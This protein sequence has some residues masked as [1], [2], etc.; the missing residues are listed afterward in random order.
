M[1]TFHTR[2]Q[3]STRASISRL[4]GEAEAG[5]EGPPPHPFPQ[6]LGGITHAWNSS[7]ILNDKTIFCKGT[8]IYF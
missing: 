8:F 4:A 2:M 5:P 7:E 1:V 3:P 6:S